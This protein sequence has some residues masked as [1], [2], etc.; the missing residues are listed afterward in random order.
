M[1]SHT[2][3]Q[4]SPGLP[5]RAPR[6]KETNPL[7]WGSMASTSQG[8][9]IMAAWE[10]DQRVQ[11]KVDDESSP[12]GNLAWFSYGLPDD[13]VLHLTHGGEHGSTK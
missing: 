9:W 5:G 1:A 7:A 4:I 2:P 3:K 8:F 10:T 12:K 13:F 6:A 11:P